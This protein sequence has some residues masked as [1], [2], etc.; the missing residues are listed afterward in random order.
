MKIS[1]VLLAGGES[2]RMGKDKATLLFRGKPLWQIQFELLRKLEPAEILVSARE[3][4]AWRPNDIRFVADDSP[5]RGPLSGLAASLAQ[6]Q[7]GHLLALGIDMPFMSEIFLRSLCDQME[8][9]CGVLPMIDDR[10]E[11][12]TAIYPA[13]G[14][15]DFLEALSG[16]DFSLQSL[17]KKL[18]KEGKLRAV[19]VPKEKETLFRSLNE[20]ADLN[21]PR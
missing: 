14:H 9:G 6:I 11:P 3:D 5:S 12:L 18:V 7:T 13:D 1:A 8:P 2:R 19:N 10:A 4:P 16:N 20:P 17:T 21:L 15:V